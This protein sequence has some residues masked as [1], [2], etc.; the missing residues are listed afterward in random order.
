VSFRPTPIFKKVLAL[1][2]RR[3]GPRN[4]AWKIKVQERQSLIPESVLNRDSKAVTIYFANAARYDLDRLRFQLSHAAIHFISGAFKR[5]ALT[6]EEGLAVYFSLD[7]SEESY[8]HRA[9][10]CL[11]A[12]FADALEKF[13]ALKGHGRRDSRPQT[14]VC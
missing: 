1:A 13:R 14:T 6:F 12:M 7:V 4:G 9:E 8:R 10:A 5:E 3:Y 2:E 11:P